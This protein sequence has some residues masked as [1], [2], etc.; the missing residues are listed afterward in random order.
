MGRTKITGWSVNQWYP[1]CIL[2]KIWVE[3]PPSIAPVSFSL[4]SLQAWPEKR[5]ERPEKELAIILSNSYSGKLVAFLSGPILKWFFFLNLNCFEMT[6]LIFYLLYT[7]T[8]GI[9]KVMWYMQWSPLFSN[10]FGGQLVVCAPN[11]C[12]STSFIAHLTSKGT[13]SFS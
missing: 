4:Y 12:V 3:V 5:S 6:M 10:T 8:G 11:V 2:S 13:I 1:I 9:V 7:R